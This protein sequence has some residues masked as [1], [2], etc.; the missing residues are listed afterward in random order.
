[1]LTA[2]TSLTPVFTAGVEWEYKQIGYQEMHRIDL[3]AAGFT[4]A[5]AM[6]ALR[7]PT[8]KPFSRRCRLMKM[9]SCPARR[10]TSPD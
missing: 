2:T 4:W 3:Q 1:M 7:L 10:V 9:A 8:P 5:N 6:M